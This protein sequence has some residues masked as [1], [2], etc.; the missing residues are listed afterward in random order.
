MLSWPR[1]ARYG[2]CID[3]VCACCSRQLHALS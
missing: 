1:S 3:M 2:R